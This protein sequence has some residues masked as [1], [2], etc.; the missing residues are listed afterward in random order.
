MQTYYND[1]LAARRELLAEALMKMAKEGKPMIRVQ[2]V[3]YRSTYTYIFEGVEFKYIDVF[4]D[5]IVVK[6]DTATKRIWL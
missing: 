1:L 5:F 6:I 3:E 2:D 4:D